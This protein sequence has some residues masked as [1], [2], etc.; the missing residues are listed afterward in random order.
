M[1]GFKGLVFGANQNQ[2]VLLD[3]T[4]LLALLHLAMT[5]RKLKTEPLIFLE[6]IDLEYACAIGKSISMWTGFARFA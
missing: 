6:V 4:F 1:E 3:N 2:L 5:E